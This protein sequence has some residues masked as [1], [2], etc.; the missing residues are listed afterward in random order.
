MSVLFLVMELVPDRGNFRLMS[1]WLMSVTLT[2]RMQ[3]N[4]VPLKSKCNY[5]YTVSY[6]TVWAMGGGTTSRHQ[7]QMTFKPT[8]Q[9]F[10]I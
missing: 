10:N 7:K 5:S 1:W 6:R 8:N 2:T 9:N 4:E 3:K